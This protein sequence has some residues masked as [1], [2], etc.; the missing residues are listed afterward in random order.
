MSD[1]NDQMVATI[2]STK[3]AIWPMMKGL[4]PG[5]QSAIIA[6]MLATLLAGHAPPLRNKTLR[7]IIRLTWR[8]V[9]I[10]EAMLFG[11]NGHPYNSE[12]NKR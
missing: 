2:E 3:A 12:E 9:P 1:K 4:G 8:L 11:G 10:N 7:L 5:V 6:D